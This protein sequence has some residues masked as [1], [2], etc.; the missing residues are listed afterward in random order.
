MPFVDPIKHTHLVGKSATFQRVPTYCIKHWR[1]LDK[2]GTITVNKSSRTSLDHL[3]F[4]DTALRAGI[5]YAASILQF[6]AYEG[7]ICVTFDLRRTARSDS[8][9]ETER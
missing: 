2:R 8:S 7:K 6:R 1:D 9:E 4:I 5:P 3:Y